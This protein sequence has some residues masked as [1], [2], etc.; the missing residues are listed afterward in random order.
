MMD[1]KASAESNVPGIKVHI[2]CPMIRTDDT[3]ANAKLVK[4]KKRL[5]EAREN[6]E[7]S[8]ILNDNITAEKHLSEK[9]L[10]LSGYGT[11]VLA[12][13]MIKFIRQL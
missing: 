2:S 13:N 12:T 9:G 4:V 8:I 10:H 6:E 3:R 1:L 5:V 11:K 7:L